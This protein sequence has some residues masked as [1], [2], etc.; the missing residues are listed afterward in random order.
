MLSGISRICHMCAGVGVFTEVNANGTF[1]QDPCNACKGT[2]YFPLYKIV[3]P[4]GIY[5]AHEVFEAINQT[6]YDALSNKDQKTCDK[7]V[8]CGTIDLNG[9]SRAITI[10]NGLFGSDSTTMENLEN[11]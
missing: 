6:E 1:V 2:G 4:V 8:N 3:L 5:H 11:L 7:V 9:G 10:L